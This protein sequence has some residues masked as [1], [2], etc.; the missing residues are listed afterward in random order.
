MQ[1]RD[2][3][4]GLLLST[5]KVDGME[6]KPL[7]SHPKPRSRACF[8]STKQLL[9]SIPG[10]LRLTVLTKKQQVWSLSPDLFMLTLHIAS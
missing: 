9:P 10:N 3:V 2:I 7:Y 6:V 8:Y 5:D 1:K 4:F